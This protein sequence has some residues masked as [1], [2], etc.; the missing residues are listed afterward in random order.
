MMYI[1]CNIR[2]GSITIL[3]R[4]SGAPR[5]VNK[6]LQNFAI[7]LFPS[8]PDQNRG[9][10][11]SRETVRLQLPLNIY[12]YRFFLFAGARRRLCVRRV[13]HAKPYNPK[14][15]SIRVICIFIEHKEVRRL[16]LVEKQYNICHFLNNFF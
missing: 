10:R 1:L 16:L 15:N 12:H 3:F 9:W 7:A 11:I 4:A 13:L 8:W 6:K 2:F 5:L 14:T